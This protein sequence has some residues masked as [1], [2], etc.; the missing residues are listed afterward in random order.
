MRAI[1]TNVKRFLKNFI[2]KYQYPYLRVKNMPNS[3][4][5]RDSIY[6]LI[7]Q[8]GK[9]EPVGLTHSLQTGYHELPFNDLKFKVSRR[10]LDFRLNRICKHIEV[11]EKQ[12]IDIGSALGGITFGLQLRGAK[13]VGIE[14]DALFY[15]SRQRVRSLLP[16]R[17]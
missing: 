17:G 5:S 1:L 12:G 2:E 6:F 16:N 15:R 4:P 9:N 8:L 14:R 11:H 13:M 7:N 3:R 10:D